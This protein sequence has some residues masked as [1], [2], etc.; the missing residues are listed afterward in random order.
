[1]N[2]ACSTC[3]GSFTSISN[4][5]AIPCGH[6]FHTDCIKKWLQNG[7]NSCSQCRKSFQRK[8]ITKL[9]FST[10]HSENDLMLELEEAKNEAEERSLKFQKQNVDLQAEISDVKNENLD[11]RKEN[12]KFREENLQL[13]RHLKDLQKNTEIKEKT[14]NKRIEE[15]T[16]ENK[17]LNSEEGNPKRRKIANKNDITALHQAASKGN[18]KSVKKLLTEIGDRNARNKS[19]LTPLH[20]AALNGHT[21]IIKLIFDVVDEKSEILGF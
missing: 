13:S 16:K 6:V 5:S 20:K 14:S 15:L 11:L 1:M 10:S 12:F 8:E 19:G 17:N 18:A 21:N 3:F 9:F 4:I 7:S 2:A